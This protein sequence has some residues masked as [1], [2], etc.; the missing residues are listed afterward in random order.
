MISE[1]INASFSQD[2]KAFEALFVRLTADNRRFPVDCLERL[3]DQV[4][5]QRHLGIFPGKFTFD[6]YS[7][8]HKESK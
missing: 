4:I 1:P 5:T 3:R 2:L 8:G 7:L 6:S